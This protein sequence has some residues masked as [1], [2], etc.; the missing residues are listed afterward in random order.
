MLS[1]FSKRMRHAIELMRHTF[2]TAYSVV[3][4]TW[5]E[6]YQQVVHW[7]ERPSLDWNRA[8]A[9]RAE[10]QASRLLNEKIRQHGT[11]SVFRDRGDAEFSL[12]EWK[13]IRQ[14]QNSVR[15]S[16]R[17]NISRTAA[18]GRIYQSYPELHWALLAHMVSRN[19]GWSMTDLQGEW[20]PR[21]MNANH[22]LWTYRV[23]ER[24]NAL[25]FHDAYPQLLLYAA[26]R[27]A[28]KSLFHLLPAFGVSSFMTPFWDG[29]WVQQTSS[30]LTTALIIN[31]QNVIEGRVIQNPTYRAHVLNEW[32]FQLHGWM[33]MNQVIFPLGVP[34]PREEE[35]VPL[36]GLN[37]GNFT[38]LDERITFGKKLYA[39]LLHT[40]HIYN[41]TV[42]FIRAVPHTGS[43]ADY[44]PHRFVKHT[45]P[46]DKPEL[47]RPHRAYSPTL[48]DVWKDEPA[49]QIEE[50]DWFIDE[51]MYQHLQPIQPPMQADMT[52][53][54]DRMWRETASLAGFIHPGKS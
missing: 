20:L 42:R 41:S 36:V 2:D 9:K 1:N 46:S 29:F 31:E 23:L 48:I 34:S 51:R 49:R 37:L 6:L 8:A 12:E 53:S 38:D 27:R 10:E 52:S 15:T 4:S 11:V 39:L 5:N 30:L 32:D 28:G 40:P 26:S 44:W 17:N 45:A 21:I 25:I 43:R 18:Y 22:R 35:A 24:S 47:S 33:Q 54:H 16:N 50:G 14:I 3:R 19:G 13:L 7:R